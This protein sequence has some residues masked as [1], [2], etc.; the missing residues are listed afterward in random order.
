MARPDT[1]TSYDSAGQ[2]ALTRLVSGG[3]TTDGT[4]PI[5]RSYD[6]YGRVSSYTDGTGLVTTSTYVCLPRRKEV[7]AAEKAM[8]RCRSQRCSWVLTDGR[9]GLVNLHLTSGPEIE[10]DQD[11]L[12]PVCA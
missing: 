6:A 9:R 5:G 12:N 10:R 8:C 1:E 4:G 2:L 7:R 3:S 11:H